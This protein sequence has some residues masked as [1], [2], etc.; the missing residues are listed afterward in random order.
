MLQ[1]EAAAEEKVDVFNKKVVVFEVADQKHVEQH[2][3]QEAEPGKP[4]APVTFLLDAQGQPIVHQD[5]GG[6]EQQVFHIVVAV[7]HQRGGDEQQ[8]L[9]PAQPARRSNQP[10][11]QVKAQQHQRQKSEDEDIG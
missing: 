9:N 5:G 8:V 7:K 11:Q 6:D 10:G 2:A 4:P 1:R 3:Q